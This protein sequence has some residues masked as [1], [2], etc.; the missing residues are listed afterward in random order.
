MPISSTSM[1]NLIVKEFWQLLDTEIHY[2]PGANLS[3]MAG[4]AVL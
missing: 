4:L 3:H 2:V 1:D